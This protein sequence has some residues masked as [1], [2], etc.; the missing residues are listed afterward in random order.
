[1]LPLNAAHAALSQVLF[2]AEGPGPS[3]QVDLSNPALV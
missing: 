1:M 2:P 3:G